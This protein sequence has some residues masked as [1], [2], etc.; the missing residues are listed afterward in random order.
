MR[1]LLARYGPIMGRFCSISCILAVMLAATVPVW[2]QEVTAAITGTVTDPTGAAVVGATVTATDLERG[3]K[4]QTTTNGAGLY[5]FPRLPVSRYSI[6]VEA[7]GFQAAV[8]PEV[9]L[10]LNQIAKVDMQLQVGNITQTVEVS[11][12]API[13]QTEST[14][15]STLI[16]SHA[17]ESMP[18]STRNYGQLALLA[19]GAV[20]TNASAFAGGSGSSAGLNTFYSGRPYINGNREQ[21]DNYVLDGLDNNQSDEGGVAYAPSPDAIQEFDLITTN[22]SAEFGNY[23]G[24]IINATL[25]SG[26][27]QVHG[28]AFEFFRNDKLN[29][30]LWQNNWNNL[31]RP[32]LRYNE[33]GGTV[34]G[35]IVKNKLFFFADYQGE[36]YDQPATA[37][38]FTVFSA[39]ERQGNFGDLCTSIGGSFNSSGACSK[40][41]GQLY[42]PYSSSNPN[43][44]S[45]F[46]FNQISPTM[47][48]PVAAK[49]LSSSLYP[50]PLNNNFTNNQ[51][52][53]SHSYTNGDQGDIKVDWAA[54]DKDHVYAR[55]TQQYVTN[56]TTNSQPL[57]FNSSN[58]FPLYSGVLD[59]T[60][61]FSPSF[62]NDA[63]VGVNYFPVSAYSTVSNGTGQN[64]PSVFGIPGVPSTFLPTIDL[65]NSLVSNIGTTDIEQAFNDTVIQAEDTAIIAK[66]RH[67][68]HVGFQFLR[69]RDDVFYS[70]QGGAAG[71]FDFNGQYTA[72]G[73]GAV[74]AGNGGA[75]FLL[76]M[77]EFLEL[78][79]NVGTRGLRY[80]AYGAFFQDDW[81]VN[82]HLTLNLGLRYE[83]HT[84]EY[85]VDNRA[86]NYGEFTGQV[87]LANNGS[88][89]YNNCQA[90]YNQYNGITNWQP[91]IG[92]AWTPFG[93]N[94]V[95]RASWGVTDFF[96]GI[97]VANIPA[98]NPPWQGAGQT[99]YLP[100]QPLPGSTLSQGF[101]VLPPPVCNT[102]TVL[103]TP[104]PGACF[105][106]QTIHILDPNY[107]PTVSQQW[108][109]TVQHQFG[110]STTVQVAYV[111][112]KNTHLTN[113]YYGQ[114]RVLSPNGTVSN[115]LYLAGNPAL[116][117]ET[118]GVV[119][120]NSGIERVIDSNGYGNY[121]AFEA[122]VQ[123]RLS[124]GLELQLNYT[125]SKCLTNAPGFFGQYG[126]ANSGQTQ[127]NGG[128]AF[129]EYTYN[130][131]L[132]YGYCPNDVA[133]EFNGFVTYD[134]PFGRGRMFGKNANKVVDGVL[135]G[136]QLNLLL[137]V[138][139]GF[140]FEVTATDTSGTRS[141]NE[142]ADCI[143]S[144]IVFGDQDSSKGGY[145][146]W[147]PATFVQPGA[148]QLGT[149]GTGVIRGPGMTEAD[150]GISKL[151]HFTES[152]SLELRGEAINVANT[153]ILDAPT[154][155]IGAS[156]G[157]VQ[158]AQLP[159]NIQLA[160]KY[161]F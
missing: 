67:T 74:S 81:H 149:C 131:A 35:P 91:R 154:G 126:D 132:D 65:I 32:L 94:T 141:G 36:R 85:E 101:S 61:T 11:T 34:G 69:Y 21:D 102:T 160:L 54:T 57:L 15:V 127:A 62:V 146:Y 106:S 18:L 116:H 95:I 142:R 8:K 77:P 40:A 41:A 73:S 99:S 105:Q 7:N 64:L 155:R 27:N 66:G 14:Q 136:W 159:R 100:A 55:Y 63:R 42:N 156:F 97:G 50:A 125:Y 20:T 123:H 5:T 75:D 151:F 114:Q 60:H 139:S 53:V 119:G 108:N 51:V 1:N 138:H 129:P 56:P 133:N 111:G 145:Q 46:P 89:P 43:T 86:T 122:S 24:G 48:D 39:A 148:G 79:Q 78:G 47:I 93:N 115:S 33:F 158:S 135:G 72:L 17:I 6:R 140:P 71:M 152:Q 13:L 31:P 143:G 45:I 68:M 37:G 12:A 19:P 117:Q 76:G 26:T 29:A 121:N 112:E 104:S 2:G 157:L 83:L 9:L 10:V 82:D 44:R 4:T 88:C 150:L 96:E 3:V 107:R 92:L 38:G 30:N 22:A 25:K 103:S 110:N 98:A 49:I 130:Q 161:N 113:I 137:N 120:F 109:F 90:L 80:S 84:P 58:V 70:G 128:Y 23:L 144:P 124:N 147:D 52:N 59:W 28:D 87:Y 153:V 134:V 118:G 16:D